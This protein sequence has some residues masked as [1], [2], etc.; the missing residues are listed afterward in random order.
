V[1][2]HDVSQP[3]TSTRARG[4]LR[5]LHRKAFTPDNWNKGGQ[6]LEW[7]DD[8]ST[9]PML[10]FCRFD[11]L[12]STY[13]VALMADKTPAWREVYAGILDQLVM[14]HTTY[15]SAIDWLTQIGHDP[16]RA[17]YPEEY[18]G[19]IPAEHWGNYDAPGW[20]A[21][22]IEPWGLQMD[23]VGADGNLFYKGFFLLILG[24]HRYV[25][26]D[27]KWNKPFDM[28][29]DGENTFTWSYSGIAEHLA[30]QWRAHPEGCH[31]E[32]TKVWPYCLS[33]AGLGLMMHDTLFGTK[34]HEVFDT[35]WEHALKKYMSFNA[36][37]APEWVAMYYDP[38]IDHVHSAGPMGGFPMSLYLAPQRREVA[39]RFYEFA[40]IALGLRDSARAIPILPDR[41]FNALAYALATEFGDDVARTRL[42]ELAD[43]EL[44]PT[45]NGAEFTWGFGLNELHPRGQMNATIMVGEAGDDRAWWRL[46]NQPNLKK[47]EQPSVVGVD[48]P[49]L[50]LSEAAYDEATRTLTIVTDVGD[51]SAVGQPTAFRIENI[52]DPQRA[53]VVCDGSEFSN[54]WTLPTG[55]FQIVLDVNVHRLEVIAAT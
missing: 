54:W 22:G 6:P 24:L 26:G 27:D 32:N 40:A 23:P 51:Q 13:A 11:L 47:F 9:P 33:G 35:W 49:K 20:T 8:R 29:R 16:K 41:R 43:R 44:E 31:C 45:W 3:G 25:S 2:Q 10:N 50:G 5:Y 1:T 36:D 34:H 46:F 21:N 18:R 38:I 19:L 15:H 52:R 7:W 42:G 30:N 37:G 48:Y 12:D 28:V 39:A 55:E 17:S 4:W 14:R 53:R